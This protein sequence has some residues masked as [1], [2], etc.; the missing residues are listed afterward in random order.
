MRKEPL[1]TSWLVRCPSPA[2]ARRLREWLPGSIHPD[3][4]LTDT[5]RAFPG[6]AEEVSVRPHRLGD[7]FADIRLLP[8]PPEDPTAFRIL[9]HRLPDAGRF[10]KDLMVNVLQGIRAASSDVSIVVDG[11]GDQEPGPDAAGGG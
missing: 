2:E 4:V 6:G 7:Y 9:F 8:G 1:F 10:W 5:V 3:A 11:K